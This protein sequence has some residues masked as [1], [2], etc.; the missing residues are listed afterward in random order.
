MQIFF[1]DSVKI[2]SFFLKTAKQ[3]TKVCKSA[4]VKRQKLNKNYTDYNDYAD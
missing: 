4:E 2:S 3:V 1:F